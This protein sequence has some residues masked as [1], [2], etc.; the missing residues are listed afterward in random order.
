[1]EIAWVQWKYFSVNVHINGNQITGE[2]LTW[3]THLDKRIHKA[4]NRMDARNLPNHQITLGLQL[5]P[6]FSQ[7]KWLCKKMRDGWDCADN[8]CSSSSPEEVWWKSGK[9]KKAHIKSQLEFVTRP[10][11]DFKVNLKKALWSDETQIELFGNE[12][13]HHV[14][15]KPNTA[16]HH[17]HSSP[18]RSAVVAT[19]CC[20][21]A[22]RQQQRLKVKKKNKTTNLPKCRNILGGRKTL[23]ESVRECF[24]WTV[25]D[26]LIS[27]KSK[28]A[29]DILKNNIVYVLE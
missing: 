17:K 4:C 14:R 25:W 24:L 10:V 7:T 11:G 15:H 2:L 6:S 12:T 21:D 28:T 8:C 20:G 23:M 22:S 3:L 1:M 29:Q 16:H 27:S 13:R 26:D 9:E 5:N 18:T 19:S